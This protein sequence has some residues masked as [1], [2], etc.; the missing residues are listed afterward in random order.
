[1]N[2]LKALFGYKKDNQK[3]HFSPNTFVLS[4]NC[5]D[6]IINPTKKQIE[7]SIIH[8]L[9]HQEAFTV[10]SKGDQFIQYSTDH[11]E[12]KKDADNLYQTIKDNFTKNQIMEAFFA[13]YDGI[14]SW[15]ETYEWEPLDY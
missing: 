6:D 10:L 4:T 3:T 15:H 14:P 13:F 5:G 2:F 11:I 12:Y 8:T 1:M 7:E 9:K